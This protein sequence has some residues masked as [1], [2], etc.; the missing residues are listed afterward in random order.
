MQNPLKRIAVLRRPRGGNP[1]IAWFGIR[2]RWIGV[3]APAL[4]PAPFGSPRS[5]RSRSCPSVFLVKVRGIGRG[6]LLGLEHHRLRRRRLVLEDLE[7]P[8]D[9]LRPAGGIDVRDVEA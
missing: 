3:P 6:H 8:V 7:P 5:D 2:A 9:G 4:A 1:G